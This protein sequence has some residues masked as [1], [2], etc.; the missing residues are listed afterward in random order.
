M[1]KRLFLG[2]T[3]Q[4]D[5]K[6]VYLILSWR[7]WRKVKFCFILRFCLHFSTPNI[8]FFL[9]QKEWFVDFVLV[10]NSN[11]LRSIDWLLINY[12]FEMLFSQYIEA[13]LGF[14][15]IFQYILFYIIV[16]RNK[17]F[18]GMSNCSKQFTLLAPYFVS[19]L[20][21]ILSSLPSIS[22][23]K[24]FLSYLYFETSRHEK[25]ISF[26]FPENRQ[27]WKWGAKFVQR[28]ENVHNSRDNIVKYINLY[29]NVLI[30]VIF[31][32]LII[33]E[34]TSVYKKLC[35]DINM[36]SLDLMFFFSGI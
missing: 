18:N 8:W 10:L 28:K 2:E 24:I 21:I 17:Y 7:K 27:K 23:Y 30:D 15:Y 19:H 34:K 14:L 22:S 36:G 33:Y 12:C 31:F 20:S 3:P 25:G 32:S 29:I 11:M 35:P 9:L 13:M 16:Y 6:K 26:H 1:L 5:M 4:T